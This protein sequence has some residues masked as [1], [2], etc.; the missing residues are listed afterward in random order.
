MADDLGDEWWENQPAAASSP[1]LLFSSS[2]FPEESECT[3]SSAVQR[4]KW[5][6]LADLPKACLTL[7]SDLFF[8]L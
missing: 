6:S 8:L 3:I 4:T 1:D 7:E 5:M 2:P